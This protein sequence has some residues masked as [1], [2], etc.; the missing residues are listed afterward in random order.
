MTGFATF[1]ADY[2]DADGVIVPAVGPTTVIP[3]TPAVAP[4]MIKVPLIVGGESVPTLPRMKAEMLEGWEYVDKKY[5]GNTIINNQKYVDSEFGKSM[6]EIWQNATYFENPQNLQNFI[7]V[8]GPYTKFFKA[9][10][11]STP[12]FQSR[13]IMANAV[14]YVLAGGKFEN[15]LP[16]HK[17]Y[18]NWI[19]AYNSG[20][21]WND[22]VKALPQQ[23]ANHVIHARNSLAMSGGAIFGD[24]FHTVMKGNPISDN[25]V[26]RKMGKFAQ[27]SDNVS[28]FALAYDS[29]MRGSLSEQMT[30][31]RIKKFYIDYED[32]SI[33][34][35]YM[36]LFMP[37]WIWTSRNFFVQLE[38]IFLNPKPYQIY[39]SFVRN[40]S[41]KD[42]EDSL[43]KY[44]KSASGWGIPGVPLM[45][46]PDLNFNRAKETGNQLLNARDGLGNIT[47][48]LKVPIEQI[49]G[50]RFYNDKE[51]EGP[52]DRL[53]AILKGLA[54]PV[55]MATRLFGTEGDNQQN[56]LLGFLGSPVKKIP[57]YE[58]G[59]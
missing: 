49:A 42:K 12:G 21:T 48:L 36:R 17:A 52:Q 4:S 59:K 20:V 41:D 14:Q 43:P 47:P 45:A 58:Q 34:D 57:Y 2:V 30:A 5:F 6:A 1:A 37:F 16:A 19:K 40:M 11:I 18:I 29:S 33:L 24:V 39:H 23:Q 35:E 26:T 7:K 31:A 3:T 22:Y 38:N 51:F 28:R 25:M 44:A 32:V 13:N 8:I 53:S 15:F 54:P 27:D 55:E 50:K 10:I 9:Y 56:A 46:V